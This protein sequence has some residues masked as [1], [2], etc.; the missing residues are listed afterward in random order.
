M[1]PVRLVVVALAAVL[2]LGCASSQW[3]GSARRAMR[4]PGERLVALPEEVAAEH[5]CGERSLPHFSLERNE[6]NPKRVRAGDELNHRM[7]YAM[8]PARPTEVIEGTLVTRFRHK[9]RVLR[10]D[11]LSNFEIKPG[12]WSVDAFIRVPPGAETGVYALEIAFRSST[13]RFEESL[14]FGVDALPAE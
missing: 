2:F 12:R 8:C 13:L 1:R 7:V 3:M 14:E 6:V 5:G 10:S 9:G 4:S 11:P